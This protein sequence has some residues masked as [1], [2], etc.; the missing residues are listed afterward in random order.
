MAWV[1]QFINFYKGGLTHAAAQ[2]FMP[3]PTYYG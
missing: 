1:L 2:G 3:D